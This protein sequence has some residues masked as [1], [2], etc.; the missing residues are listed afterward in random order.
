MEQAQQEKVYMERLPLVAII[1]GSTTILSALYSCS[2]SAIT[3]INASED[4]I[5][6]FILSG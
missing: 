4:T 5:P 6:I 1:T 2:L 3:R